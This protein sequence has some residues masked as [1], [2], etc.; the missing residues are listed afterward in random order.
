MDTD[1]Q[2]KVAECVRAIQVTKDPHARKALIQLRKLWRNV[3]AGSAVV[4]KRQLAEEIDHLSQ[5]HA[6]LMPP[7]VH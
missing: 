4:G 3:A 7:T 2:E 1:F 5:I 6:R